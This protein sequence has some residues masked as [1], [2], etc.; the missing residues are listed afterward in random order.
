[1]DKK[2]GVWLEFSNILEGRGYLLGKAQL[3]QFQY[4]HELLCEANSQF[5]LTRIT[6][7]AEAV[8]KHYLDAYLIYEVLLEQKMGSIQ[9]LLDFGSGTGVPGIPLKILLENPALY[10]VDAR[11]KKIEYLKQTCHSLGF[12]GVNMIHANWNPARA[13][14]WSRDEGRLDLVVARA[15][16]RAQVLLETLAPICKKALILPKG[17]S[18]SS[19]DWASANALAQRLGF[20][21]GKAVSTSIAFGQE[22][23]QR[24]I[25]CWVRRK[26]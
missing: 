24:K 15:V 12:S 14:A 19:Q 22:E 23:I 4:F 26:T 3:K 20:E 2:G 13:K 18:F 25:L 17:P 7:L 1:M 10:L 21:S 5:N 6:D 16:G 11:K 9:S 8:L